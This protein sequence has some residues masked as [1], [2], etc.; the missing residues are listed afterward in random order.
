MANKDR[1]PAQSPEAEEMRLIS[2][3]YALAQKQ[4][5]EGTASSQVI[6]YFLNLGSQKAKLER[7]LLKDQ[8]KLMKAKTEA[9]ESTKRMDELFRDAAKA[10]RTYGGVDEKDVEDGSL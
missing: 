10:L 2:S 1:R 5:D 7:E 6:S 8:Q 3:A 4:L 9:L